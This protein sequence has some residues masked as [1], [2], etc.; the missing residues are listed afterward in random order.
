MSIARKKFT[1]ALTLC[2]LLTFSAGESFAQ[3]NITGVSG[4]TLEHGGTITI[5][6]S[7]FGIKDPAAPL[8]WDDFENGTADNDLDNGWYTYSS[9]G[10]FP[11]YANDMV[12][13]GSLSLKQDFTASG[14]YNCTFGLTNLSNDKYYITFYKYITTSGGESRNYKPLALRGGPPGNWDDPEIRHDMYPTNK[15]GQIN[16]ANCNGST[17]GKNWDGAYDFPANSGSW[18]RI[19]YYIDGGDPNVANGNY[20]FWSDGELK[21]SIENAVFRTDSSCVWTNMYISSYLATDTNSARAYIWHDD[22]YID[23]TRAR[24]EIGNASTWSGSTHREIQIPSAWS[25]TSVAIT[26]NQGSF[27]DFYNVYLYIFD[28]NGNVNSNGYPLYPL[29]GDNLCPSPPTNLLVE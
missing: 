25:D 9:H 16:A 19:E 7:G 26:L 10:I 23:T 6:G 21:T 8:K 18:N 12:R 17:V 20:Y 5:T 11:K 2:A 1:I 15:S 22:V 29:Y 14:Q 4:G 3:P 13:S 28:E 27:S 24:V